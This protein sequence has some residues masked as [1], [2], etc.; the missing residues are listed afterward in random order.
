MSDERTVDSLRRAEFRSAVRGYDR[1][2]VDAFR[3]AALQRLDALEAELGGLRAKLGALGIDDPADLKVELDAVGSE[4]GRILGA[5]RETAEGLRRRAATDADRWRAEAGS[6]AT[7]TRARAQADAEALRRAAWETGSTLLEQTRAEAE[8]LHQAAHDETLIIRADAEREAIRLTGDARRQA[9]EE[10]RGA[11]T[12]AEQLVAQAREERDRVLA[13]ARHQAEAAQ[14]R[15][16]ALEERRSEL[17]ADIESARGS[18]AHLDRELDAKR[19]A[20][21]IQGAVE[22]GPAT[23]APDA[24]APVPVDWH[25][26]DSGVRILPPSSVQ[27][28]EP[29][30]ADAMADEVQRLRSEQSTRPESELEPEFE[31]ESGVE[32]ES[33]SGPGLEPEPEPEPPGPPPDGAPIEPASAE[34]ESES[35]E[36]EPE[37][38]AGS[39]RDEPAPA[40][41]LDALF[42]SLRT[43]AE[44]EVLAPADAAVAVPAESGTIPEPE[45]VLPVPVISP[46]GDPFEARERALLPVENR[47]LRDVK[48]SLV[49]LQNVVLEELRVD[50]TRWSPDD[51][52]Y[53]G[54]LAEPFSELASGAAAAG[55]AAA[56]ATQPGPPPAI[57]PAA[58]VDDFVAGLVGDIDHALQRQG[59]KRN[60]RQVQAAVSRVFRSWRTDEAERRIRFAAYAAYHRG[61]LDGFVAAGVT[62]VTAIAAG[63]PCP[64]CPAAVHAVW[65]PSGPP[66]DGIGLP[67][68]R[69]DCGCVIVASE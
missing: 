53:R 22:A 54:A 49:D 42:A 38:P 58:A 4:V 64:E 24:P 19:E 10:L 17:M 28:H 3:D 26:D 52:A 9:E 46:S 6:E 13:D 45:P 57:E 63:L 11:R 31:P 34:P 27:V 43:P 50:A 23:S 29:V 33:E 7:A 51:A 25:E 18:I 62:R 48:R 32:P 35:A 14:E 30:D 56:G 16:R 20:L 21:E 12:R 5:A 60:G 37:L 61:L 67:P 47:V 68:T 66:P 40:S 69:A 36:S 41:G 15:A 2:E 44:A 8:S 1:A 39:V 65:D 55:W 59:S